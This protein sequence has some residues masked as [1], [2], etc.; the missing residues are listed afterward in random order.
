MR[1]SAIAAGA[2]AG[3][4]VMAAHAS[5]ADAPPLKPPRAP[6]QVIVRYEKG[7]SASMR[8]AARDAV[9]ASSARRILLPDTQVLHVAPGTAR[10]ASRELEHLDSVRWAEPNRMVKGGAAAT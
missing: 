7:A 5:A 8:A 1:R 6:A 4:L 10:E 3:L 2:V 9:D